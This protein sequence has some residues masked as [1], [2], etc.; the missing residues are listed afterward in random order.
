MDFDHIWR[1]LGSFLQLRINNI[2][3]ES[4]CFFPYRYIDRSAFWQSENSRLLIWNFRG[5]MWYDWLL[6]GKC[7]SY[8]ILSSFAGIPWLPI[9]MFRL[10]QLK[11]RTSA[12]VV[13]FQIVFLNFCFKLQYF[14]SLAN[15][16]NSFG[17]QW[18]L[19]I[20]ACWTTCDSPECS[21]LGFL[22]NNL[23]LLM[24]W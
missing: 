11:A 21:R 12:C 20:A 1:R 22:W 15:L 18:G 23:S 19:I 9:G 7:L 10:S 14:Q 24:L 5:T 8:L 4:I 6:A 3:I 13:I 2:D 17:P 16:T